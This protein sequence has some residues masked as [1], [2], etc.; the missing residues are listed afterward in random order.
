MSAEAEQTAR[1]R[2]VVV[3]NRL[4]IKIEKNDGEWSVTAGS[5]GLVTAMNPVLKNRGGIWIGW[6]GSTEPMGL[7]TVRNI[8]GPVSRESGYRLIPVLM[9]EE[10]RELYYEGFANAVLWP[11]FHDF[12]QKCHFDPSYWK[13][14]TRVNRMFA[15]VT[16]RHTREQDFVWI[17]DYHLMGVA[18]AMKALGVQRNCA[19]FLHIPF[20]T[21]DIFLRLPWRQE[22]L[23]SLLEYSFVAFQ[24]IRDR[25]NFV[26]CVRAFWPKARIFGRGPTIRLSLGEST[27]T[28]GAFPISIDFKEFDTL[29]GTEAVE[30]EMERLKTVH[31]DKRLMLGV[32]R[33]DYSKGIP[34]RLKAYENALERYPELHEQLTYIQLVVPSREGVA[35]YQDL[36]EEIE[37]IVARINGKFTTTSWVPVV[38]MYRAIP[39]EQLVALYRFADIAL[40]TP[41]KDG[42]NLV[43]KEFCASSIDERGVV[44]L[45]EFAGSAVQM[46]RYVMAV[47]PH[48]MEHLADSIVRA[49]NMPGYRQRR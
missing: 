46:N 41:L 1:E 11:L 8:L 37:K 43:S 45:S 2:L 42:M 44:I 49:F 36:R 29:A 3:S 39:K 33:L 23:S 40:I 12:P 35:A 7:R 32:D 19:F 17:H 47:N 31:R 24:T 26:S 34:E 28:L 4:P 38:F 10:D 16:A 18:H 5:G 27:I 20:P 25:R 21:P 15:Q 22:I 13:G 6:T 14:Y 30:E 48:D 9:G